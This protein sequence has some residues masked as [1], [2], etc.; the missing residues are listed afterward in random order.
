MNNR[1]TTRHNNGKLTMDATFE[2]KRSNTNRVYTINTHS[3]GKSSSWSQ[4]C[5]RKG[6]V[7]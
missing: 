2:K 1:N 6:V 4:Q 7:R 3:G 5:E